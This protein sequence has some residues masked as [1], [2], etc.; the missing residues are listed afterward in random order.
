MSVLSNLIGHGEKRAHAAVVAAVRPLAHPLIRALVVVALGALYLAAFPALFRALGPDVAALFVMAVLPASLAYGVF[1][2]VVAGGLALPVHLVLLG[3]IGPHALST[4][5]ADWAGAVTGIAVGVAAGT[6]RDLLRGKWVAAALHGEPRAEIGVAPPELGGL[7]LPR[8]DGRPAT[9]IAAFLARPG[10][11]RFR[12][13]ARPV[14][15][16]AVA[17]IYAGA[18]PTLFATFGPD[19]AALF[20]LAVLPASLAYGLPG[21]VLAGAIAVPAHVALLGA[22]GPQALAALASDWAGAVTGVTVGVASGAARDLLR[23]VRSQTTILE[24]ERVRLEG[25]IVRRERTERELA[26]TNGELQR[27]REVAERAARAKSV[28]LG[29]A[30]HELRTPVAA[31]L[32]YVELIQE[33]LR[34]GV[35]SSIDGDLDRIHAAAAHLASLLD[36]LL[37]I[38]RL[39]SGHF[40]PHNVRIVVGELVREVAVIAA[41]LAAR[42]GNRLALDVLD[43]EAT[44]TSDRRRIEQIVLNLLANAAKYTAGGTIRLVARAP[45]PTTIELSVSDEGVG[46][47]AEQAARAFDEFYRADPTGSEGSGLGLPICRHLCRALGG[48]IQLRSAPGQGTTFTVTLPVEPPRR[49]HAP[50]PAA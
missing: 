26:R 36:D 39:E 2:G 50:A 24:R 41:P 22:I 14:T 35:A 21:G 38:A 3:G 7:A 48:D 29:R 45:S 18:F 5:W 31:V 49:E 43:A 23:R 40:A 17:A 33:E 28:L 19:V 15:V 4:L 11:V 27:A 32:G 16:A 8:S 25:E 6:A 10:L 37:D 44:F 1:G 30:S 47:T 13:A 46:M 20:V 12:P 9:P 42:R 34:A